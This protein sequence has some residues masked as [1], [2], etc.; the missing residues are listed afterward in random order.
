VYHN[1]YDCIPETALCLL[2]RFSA[3]RGDG[4]GQAQLSIWLLSSPFSAW[5]VGVRGGLSYE[6]LEEYSN[7]IARKGGVDGRREVING[8]MRAICRPVENQKF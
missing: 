6:Q 2:H 7:A 3:Q 1:R 8:T 4:P 5:F